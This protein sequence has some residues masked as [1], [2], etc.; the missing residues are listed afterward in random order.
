M[1]VCMAG[2]VFRVCMGG[3]NISGV[4]ISRDSSWQAVYYT[5]LSFPS[6]V[7]CIISHEEDNSSEAP[8]R[9]TGTAVPPTNDFLT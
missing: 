8:F 5:D 9:T 4:E 3:P 2:L 6:I 1:V 7:E